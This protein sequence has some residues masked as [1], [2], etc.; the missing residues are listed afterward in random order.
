M[1]SDEACTK[2]LAKNVISSYKASGSYAGYPPDSLFSGG[3]LQPE[4][5]CLEGKTPN[6]CKDWWSKGLNVRPF[7][8]LSVYCVGCFDFLCLI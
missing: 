2:K 5:K 6:T 7:S 8:K 3:S 1:Y 4:T